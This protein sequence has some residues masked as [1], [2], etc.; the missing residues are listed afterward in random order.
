MKIKIAVISI[1]L[2]LSMLTSCSAITGKASF[3]RLKIEESKIESVEM[4]SYPNGRITF[5]EEETDKL[6][7]LFNNVPHGNVPEGEICT[8]DTIISLNYKNGEKTSFY[9]YGE[10]YLTLEIKTYDEDG[11]Q[12]KWYYFR[13]D[14]L[15]DFVYETGK[16]HFEKT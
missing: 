14:E 5:S 2:V 4:Y 10:D 7:E 6:I 8:P 1:I 12:D 3:S 15:R 11:K 13:S 9:F 16:K